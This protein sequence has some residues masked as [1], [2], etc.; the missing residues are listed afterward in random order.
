MQS[1][2]LCDWSPEKD[3]VDL[4]LT[5]RLT[6]VQAV[7]MSVRSDHITTII[8]LSFVFYLGPNKRV[9]SYGTHKI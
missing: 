4:P 1:D 7:K 3:V 5:L 6:S 9:S 8:I 2:H